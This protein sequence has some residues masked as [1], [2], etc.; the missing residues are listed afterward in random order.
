MAT[1]RSNKSKGM[2]FQKKCR[3]RILQKFSSIDEHDIRTA[4]ANEHGEDIKCTPKVLEILQNPY[5]E[6]KHQRRINWP[7][8][9]IS[10]AEKAKKRNLNPVLLGAGHRDRITK[11]MI[12]EEYFLE[13]Q[14]KSYLY[15]LTLKGDKVNEKV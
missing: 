15:D 12:T 9:F 7:G 3:N 8:E 1:A 4:I 11:V 13:L 2:L 14:Y 10:T 5:Y 6:C